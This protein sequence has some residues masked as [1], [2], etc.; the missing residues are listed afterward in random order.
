MVDKPGRRKKHSLPW[1]KIA[2]IA[3]AA[4]VIVAAGYYVYETYVYTPPPEYVK[5]GTTLGSFYVEL[6]PS[7]ARQTVSNFVSLVNS[8]FYNDLVWHRIVPGFVI[9]S[10]DPNSR[11]GLNSTRTNWGEGGS[12]NT[13]PL[14]ICGWLHN[15]AGYVGMAR[16]GNQTYGLDTGTSQFYILL[17]NQSA[18]TFSALDGYYTIFGKVISGMSV[19]CAIGKV[20]TYSSTQQPVNPVYVTNMT[21]ISASAAPTPQTVVGCKS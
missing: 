17:D 20:P 5:V 1:G 10:G 6:F 9:Q 16:Q 15:Y 4:V 7:C 2:A 13:V 19:V 12:N 11:G 14:E 8:G 21:T 3:I 18:Q